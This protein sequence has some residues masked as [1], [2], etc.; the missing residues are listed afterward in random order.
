MA[1]LAC[2]PIFSSWSYVDHV[3]PSSVGKPYVFLLVGFECRAASRLQSAAAGWPL[4]V[5]PFNV[6]MRDSAWRV[7]RPSQGQRASTSKTQ[8]LAMRI[9]RDGREV[10]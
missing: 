9:S 7:G 8:T 2:T 6:D 3:E 10:I 1:S 5:A 4:L